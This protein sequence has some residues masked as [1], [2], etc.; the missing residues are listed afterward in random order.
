M[1]KLKKEVKPIKQKFNEFEQKYFLNDETGLIENQEENKQLEIDKFEDET[2][3]WKIIEKYEN[4]DLMILNKKPE[5]LQRDENGYLDASFMV[6][7]L[8]D[9]AK[10]LE[11]IK[12]LQKEIIEQQNKQPQPEPVKTQEPEQETIEPE[13]KGEQK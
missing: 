11:K 13:N 9:N 12:E 7:D 10:L 2:N 1:Q 4:G 6:N 3:I 8:T 5:T